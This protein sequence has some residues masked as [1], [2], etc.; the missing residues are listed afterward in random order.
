MGIISE[1]AIMQEFLMR[2][3]SILPCSRRLT[4]IRADGCILFDEN[5]RG[6]LD[7][8][9][10]NGNIIAGHAVAS[11]QEAYRQPSIQAGQR[12][13][14][15]LQQL[16]PGYLEHF[17]LF[18][19]GVDAIK[20]A[21]ALS[22]RFRNRP[23][24]LGI[25]EDIIQN[26]FLVVSSSDE[27]NFT[28]LF[29]ID[30][31]FELVSHNLSHPPVTGQKRISELGKS[32]RGACLCSLESF[33]ADL[34][35]KTAAIIIEPSIGVG[36]SIEPCRNFFGK[37]EEFCRANGI[38]LISNETQCGIGRTGSRMFGFQL[39][40]IHP[41][42]V[43]IGPSLANGYPIGVTACA[44]HFADHVEPVTAIASSSCA[45]ALATLQ[46]IEKF[47]LLRRSEQLGEIFKE[48]LQHKIGTHKL[49]RQIRGLG[50][51]IEIELENSET[52]LNHHHRT[53]ELGLIT[54]IGN[55]R[56]N[57]I[58]LTPPLIFSGEDT[59]KACRII[60]E[61]LP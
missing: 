6:Y 58:R 18:K 61:S 34:A 12:L 10:A 51:M 14:E 27:E 9:A 20:S 23:Y 32:C 5:D 21:C 26:S 59:E 3:M 44:G 13:I 15:E 8:F 40:N 55:V 16:L 39:L 43:C 11:I 53:S 56:K 36:G 2:P 52:A 35:D 57:V 41:D 17:Q 50:M 7:T 22:R 1:G 60:L 46:Q 29:S 33:F 24:I 30:T 45:A 38:D 48:I 42:I 25:S 37:L 54:G 19:S 49:V 4:F 31:H 47:D 28:P